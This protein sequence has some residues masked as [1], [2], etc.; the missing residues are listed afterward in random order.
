MNRLPYKT[1]LQ[2]KLWLVQTDTTVGFLSQNAAHLAQVKER[3]ANKPFVL[4]T[5]SFKTLKTLCRVPKIHK[6]QVRRSKKTSFAYANG[7]A[8]RVVKDARH[9]KFIRPFAWFYSTS[10]NEKALAYNEAFA[11]AKSDI[12]VEAAEGLYEGEASRIYRLGR[13]AKKRMR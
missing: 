7:R 9:A 12:I 3:A 10:A 8:V 13:S 5:A 4:V 2:N 1:T 11:F 6:R